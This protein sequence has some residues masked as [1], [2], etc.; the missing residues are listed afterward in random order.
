MRILPPRT[1]ADPLA[2]RRRRLLENTNQSDVDVIFACLLGR[3]V[4]RRTEYAHNLGGFRMGSLGDSKISDFDVAIGRQKQIGGFDVTM[5]H[6]L[7]VR[8]IE[9]TGALK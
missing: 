8:V 6:T 1:E 5:Y 7:A 4:S 3:H 9:C 2:I